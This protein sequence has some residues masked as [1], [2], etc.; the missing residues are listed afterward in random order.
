MSLEQLTDLANT[1][2][3]SALS[4]ERTPPRLWRLHPKQRRKI[5][6]WIFMIPFFAVNLLVILGPSLSTF[7]YSLT[8]WS[9]IGPAHFLGLAN[10]QQLL[11]DADFHRAFVINLLWMA[12][13]LTVPIAIGLFGAFLLSQI[14][15]FQM[16]FRAAYF[17]PYVIASVVNAAVW[18]Q[19]LD[20]QQGLAYQLDQFGIHLLDNI[21]FFGD[22]KLALPSVAFVDNW[23]FW[24]FLVV[25][26][27]SA[28]QSVDP[29]LYDAAKIDGANHWRQFYHV[30]L[31]GIRP[32]MGIVLLLVT[33]WSLLVFEYPYIIT[34]GGP[35][36][37]TQTMTILLYKNAFSLNEA[38][39]AAAMGLSM[40]FIAIAI[41][42]VYQFLQRRGVEI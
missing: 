13:F 16:L 35:A 29:G 24:G 34:Q 10:F 11:T 41:T 5:L 21:Y 22:Q 18:Q 40:S 28:M 32:V 19:I 17:I 14:K 26:F 1:S 39:Y 12:M 42:L 9:G 36:D 3:R 4:S 6:A 30:T 23:H 38:G 15:R 31:P 20:P 8:D 2:N 33:I 27:L 37:A 7:Y 25:I